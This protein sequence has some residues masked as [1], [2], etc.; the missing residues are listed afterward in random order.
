M[1]LS[2]R[3][4]LIADL[5]TPGYVTADIGTDHGF[6]PIYLLRENIAPR[7]IAVDVSEGS[8]R[9]AEENAVYFHLAEGVQ[10][11]YIYNGRKK[12]PVFA[13]SELIEFRLSDGLSGIEPGEAES[14]IIAGMGGMLM[15]RILNDGIA[16]VRSA[17][18]LILS[19]HRDLQTVID[20]VESA[21]FDIAVREEFIDKKKNYTVI[22]AV[23]V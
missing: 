4:K 13:S 18:E 1:S 10:E 12:K 21:G 15:T 16:V 7:V 5:V 14:I 23:R 22:K 8:L 20:F 17:K 3:L 6:V 9:K 2:K 19:P 11:K